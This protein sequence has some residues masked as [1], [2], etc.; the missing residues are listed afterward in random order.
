[1]ARC[2]PLAACGGLA[3]AVLALAGCG[4]STGSIS[5]PP[6][7]TH[8]A[9]PGDAAPGAATPTSPPAG[10]PT[11]AD[12]C[13]LITTQE[14]S[15]AL[16][17]AAGTGSGYAGQ[18]AYATTSGSVTIVAT[19]YPDDSTATSS[20]NATSTAAKAG[21]TGFQIV[22][23]MGDHAFLTGTGLVEFSKGS[24]VVIIQVLG[25]TPSTDAMTTL[26]QAAAG[27]I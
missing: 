6:T 3:L 15:A 7:S 18:C 21:L 23:G 4:G 27:R 22:S 14:A 11:A 10:N 16:G 2:T 20:Y 9:A 5:T 25:P 13:S 24:T 8:A 1:M 12:P 19:Q 26:G 17:V